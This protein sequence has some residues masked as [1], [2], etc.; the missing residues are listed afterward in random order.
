MDSEGLRQADESRSPSHRAL[1]GRAL[2]SM[3]TAA[4]GCT[5]GHVQNP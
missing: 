4:L 1:E 2:W 3:T 5:G